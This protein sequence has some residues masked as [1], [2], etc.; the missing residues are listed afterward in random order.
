MKY[1]QWGLFFNSV[2]PCGPHTSIGIAVIGPHNQK[3]KK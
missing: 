1:D 3:I 2:P